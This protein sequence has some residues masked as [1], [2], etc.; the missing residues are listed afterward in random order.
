MAFIF[1]V[2]AAAMVAILLH[3]RKVSISLIALGLIATLLVFWHHATDVLKIH[4]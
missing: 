2:Y 1:V 3:Q 4:W